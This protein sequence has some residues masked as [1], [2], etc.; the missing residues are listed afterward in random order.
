MTARHTPGVYLELE[1]KLPAVIVQPKTAVPAFIGYTRITSRK[2]I[3]LINV[4]QKIESLTDFHSIFGGAAD[5]QLLTLTLDENANYRLKSYRATVPGSAHAWKLYDCLRLYFDN[6]GQECYVVSVG[7]YADA[8]VPGDPVQPTIS[9]GFRTG[10]QALRKTDGP[11]LILFPDAVLLSDERLYRLQE[12]ALAHCAEL[13][14]RF[15]LF[16]L[17]KK[18]DHDTVVANFRDKTG[19]N[20]LSY[21]AAFTPWVQ[22]TFPVAVGFRNLTFENKK[23]QNLILA[24]LTTNPGWKKLVTD[25]NDAIADHDRLTSGL[26][27]I[28][29][30]GP[31]YDLKS[32]MESLKTAYKEAVMGGN[33]LAIKDAC[34]ALLDFLRSVFLLFPAWASPAP[35]PAPAESLTS[36]HLLQIIHT[37]AARGIG[38]QAEAFIRL[39]IHHDIV[40][41][42]YDGIAPATDFSHYDALRWLSL[43]VADIEEDSDLDPGNNITDVAAKAYELLTAI[44]SP[45]QGGQATPLPLVVQVEKL[46]DAARVYESEVQEKL[47]EGHPILS[48]AIAEIKFQLALVPPTGAVAGAIVKTDTRIGV[49][50]APANVLLES[51]SGLSCYIDNATQDGLNVDPNSG[52]SINAIRAFPGRGNLIFGSRTLKGNDPEWRYIPVR[53]LFIS[54]EKTL[55]NA[56]SEVVFEANDLNSWVR[57]RLLINGYLTGL[58]K[59]GALRGLSPQEAY[60]I[61]VGL[62][63]TMTARDILEGRLIVEVGL[64]AVRPAEFIKLKFTFLIQDSIQ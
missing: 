21:G 46:L 8:P 33:P 40:Q 53:R 42:I 11:S 43:R 59:A 56:L 12:E 55:S 64:A 13:Q 61:K 48:K 28:G 3:S 20:N 52:K 19:I 45:V 62:G 2:G 35:D 44:I 14:D 47:Y 31:D 22:H 39:V 23:G 17:F 7:S 54:V 36:R 10:L 1:R 24:D 29:I 60:Q 38:T 57:I 15:C 4:P 9:P 32:F 58:W 51:I 26:A 50:K 37:L 16:D 41:F 63:E 5:E 34:K 30:N 6:G 49:W 27:G 18:P 25:M